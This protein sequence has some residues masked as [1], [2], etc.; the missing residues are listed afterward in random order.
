MKDNYSF[1]LV[2][3]IYERNNDHILR[4]FPDIK[5]KY[6]EDSINFAGTNI[7]YDDLSKVRVLY[8]EN[9]NF[10][11]EPYIFATDKTANGKTLDYMGIYAIGVIE[12]LFLVLLKEP[13]MINEFVDEFNNI[14]NIFDTYDDIQMTYSKINLSNKK[15]KVS[16]HYLEPFNILFAMKS[17]YSNM[18]YAITKHYI[19]ILSIIWL[20]DKRKF[21][22]VFFEIINFSK[23]LYAIILESIIEEEIMEDLINEYSKKGIEIDKIV[24]QGS[25]ISNWLNKD[26][27]LDFN[28]IEYQMPKTN[29]TKYITNCRGLSIN[30][31]LKFYLQLFAK[32]GHMNSKE[33]PLFDYT[34]PRYVDYLDNTINNCIGNDSCSKVLRGLKIDTC[35]TIDFRGAYVWN[36]ENIKYNY[37][38]GNK[39]TTRDYYE[40][41]VL[42]LKAQLHLKPTEAPEF[43]NNDIWVNYVN[44]DTLRNAIGYILYCCSEDILAVNVDDLMEYANNMK[45]YVKQMEREFNKVKTKLAD[46]ENNYI[47]IEQY[48]KLVEELNQKNTILESK[49][50]II[51]QL[52]KENK[53]L[54]AYIE[55]IYGTDD[56]D[57]EEIELE[58][59]I[60]DMITVLNDFKFCMIGGRMELLSKL[61]E[62]GWTNIIQFDHRNTSKLFGSVTKA[63]FY[64]IN[65]KFI[66]HTLVATVEKNVDIKDVMLYY[67][68]TNT[69]QLIK[70]CYDYVQKF[71]TT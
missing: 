61:E 12:V 38:I 42:F 64:V 27:D 50:N 22:Q 17:D 4:Y 57:T 37:E 26:I 1:S 65:T 46:I 67:N 18:G 63:D 40:D 3:D 5:I 28:K 71:F 55:N 45:T 30:L 10:I 41:Y 24:S 9:K 54:N 21:W 39:R 25:I 59:S 66:S 47:S 11:I 23:P 29:N 60:N 52:N 31:A 68:G 19:S 13:K 8:D 53:E 6:K 32:Y 69:K 36:V 33:Q 49:T 70:A 20:Q 43:C 34:N 51:E 7:S 48:N 62:Y 35:S 56:D 58:V 15:S 2:T 14:L 44:L 16:K